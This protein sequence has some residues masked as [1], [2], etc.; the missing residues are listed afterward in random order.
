MPRK[1]TVYE[2]D[3]A[4]ANA[5]PNAQAKD[6]IKV[7]KTM[8]DDFAGTSSLRPADLYAL[9]SRIN[10]TESVAIEF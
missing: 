4:K 2:F 9:I 1:I 7:V 10:N 3:L 5:E 6:L 8:P